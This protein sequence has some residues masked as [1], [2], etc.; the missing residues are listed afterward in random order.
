M[1]K[2]MNNNYLGE[3]TTKDL[4][5]NYFRL[6]E[7]LSIHSFQNTSKNKKSK[8]KCDKNNNKFRVIHP[9]TN[10]KN[11]NNS[12]GNSKIQNKLSNYDIGTS[13]ETV[14]ISNYS[15]NNYTNGNNVN[16]FNIKSRSNDIGSHYFY[17]KKINDIISNN[18]KKSKIKNNNSK[19]QKSKCKNNINISSINSINKSN[20]KILSSTASYSMITKVP[21]KNELKNIRQCQKLIDFSQKELCKSTN[22]KKTCN[23]SKLKKINYSDENLRKSNLFEVN[24][25]KN[26]SLIKYNSCQNKKIAKNSKIKHKN[27][28]EEK[29]GRKINNSTTNKSIEIQNY[30]NL[31][32]TNTKNSNMNSSNTVSD[33]I[34]T[35]NNYKPLIKTNYENSALFNFYN[36]TPTNNNYN[37]I[38]ENKDLSINEILIREIKL[39]WNKIGGVTENYKELFITKV[40]ELKSNFDKLLVYSNEKENLLNIINNLNKINDDIKLRKDTITRIKNILI[41]SNDDNEIILLLSC[42]RMSTINIIHDVENFHK[43]ISYDILNGKYN[44]KNIKNYPFGYLNQLSSDTDFLVTHK[45]LKDKYLFKV[46]DPFILAPTLKHKNYK[47]LPPIGESLLK[48]IHKCYYFLFVR[49]IYGAKNIKDLDTTSKK[50]NSQKSNNKINDSND[51]NDTNLIKNNGNKFEV[52]RKNIFNYNRNQ[53]KEKNNSRCSFNNFL[54]NYFG[55]NININDNKSFFLSNKIFSH[56]KNIK[57]TD[58]NNINNDINNTEASIK[59]STDKINELQKNYVNDQT[60]QITQQQ[61]KMNYNIKDKNNNLKEISCSKQIIYPYNE[62]T[63]PPIEK[64]YNDYYKKIDI[65]QIN[66]F[67]IQKNI[68]NYADVG[69][70]PKILLLKEIENNEK[71]YGIITLCYDSINL[72]SYV[73]KITSISCV[74]NYK[75][76]EILKKLLEFCDKEI[77]YDEIILYLYFSKSNNNEFALNEDIQNEIKSKTKFKWVSLVNNDNERKIKYHYVN[78]NKEKISQKNFITL[79]SY[80]LI[81]FYDGNCQKYLTLEEYNNLYILID[82]LSIYL[83]KLELENYLQNVEGL[84]I[85]KLIKLLSD[86]TYTFICDKSQFNNNISS[87]ITSTKLI[88][89]LKNVVSK[90]KNGLLIGMNYCLMKT[91]FSN[92]FKII[93]NNYEYNIISMNEYNIEVFKLEEK[94]SE[95]NLFFI[96]SENDNMSFIVYELEKKLSNNEKKNLFQKILKKILIKDNENTSKFYKKICIPSFKYNKIHDNTANEIKL[97]NFDVIE[98][99]D[100]FEFCLEKI[101]KKEIKF[102]FPECKINE[103]EIKVINNDFIMAIL[104]NDLTLDY[105]IPAFNIFY[106]EKNCWIK[107]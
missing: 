84:K 67:N 105:Q 68:K 2:K 106:V 79:S 107:V 104:I 1:I 20:S 10:V 49:K 85:K 103:E 77:E 29:I 65:N 8:E 14:I 87:I 69:I 58:S 83:D 9:E 6:K 97:C 72:D 66:S 102:S 37:S 32:D 71:I 18:R 82:L 70:Y 54:N 76:S 98:R 28:C 22:N 16:N 38:K 73:L 80:I 13:V 44:A 61:I 34:S 48:E 50:S 26:L 63:D 12:S 53:S 41:E 46:N 25:N 40:N 75:I 51:I 81:K 31:F 57:T 24:W 23:Y 11:I 89:K 55:V 96:K 27:N 64:L 88:D 39:L 92:I 95:G 19:P 4:S 35:F 36:N 100:E 52:V 56:F 21:K 74:E 5:Q 33:Y 101:K 60:K 47:S 91:N 43:E 78:K 42:L 93:N 17:A 86:F 45:F 62:K 94:D 99:N 3:F 30:N 90:E 59:N 7:P 15:K